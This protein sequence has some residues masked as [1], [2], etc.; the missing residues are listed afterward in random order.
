L[1]IPSHYK[2][3]L[4]QTSVREYQKKIS[5]EYNSI[6]LNIRRFCAAHKRTILLKLWVCEPEQSFCSVRV[7]EARKKER[8]QQAQTVYKNKNE[9]KGTVQSLNTW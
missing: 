9:S 4:T 5:E 6:N 8:D 1:G 2:E 7:W 3:M